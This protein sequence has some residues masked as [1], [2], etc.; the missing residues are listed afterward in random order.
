MKRYINNNKL[1]NLKKVKVE[2][3]YENELKK[4]CTSSIFDFNKVSKKEEN[5]DENNLEKFNIFN[6]E[7][8]GKRRK[9]DIMHIFN[10]LKNSTQMNEDLLNQNIDKNLVRNKN[11]LVTKCIKNNVNNN[12]KDKNSNS[13]ENLN[14]DTS[15]EKIENCKTKKSNNLNKYYE[16][17]NNL[18]KEIHLSKIA[19]NNNKN[20]KYMA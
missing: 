17:I 13:N 9:I 19:R 3:E 16:K 12:I 20:I 6:L 7:E 8:N 2:C 10:E 14:K 4:E 15:V 1:Y 18:L 5:I 11:E